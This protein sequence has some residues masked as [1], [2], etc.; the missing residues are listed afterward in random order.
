MYVAAVGVMVHTT[1]EGDSTT[2]PYRT[3]DDAANA[4]AASDT[5]YVGA[6][7]YRELVTMDTSGTTGAGVIQY[8]ADVDGSQTGDPGLVVISAYDD[9]ASTA[10]RAY[11]VQTN[12]K[13]FITWKG[14]VFDGGTVAA[15][16]DNSA[17][18]NL[19]YEEVTFEE[20]VF[21]GGHTETD[22]GVYMDLNEGATP[23]TAGLTFRNCIFEGICRIAWDENAT[24]EV[25]L[26]MV[27]ES[28]LFR[29]S[30][31]TATNEGPGI[32]WDKVA[33]S[34]YMAAGVSVT[35]CM[36][37][38]CYYG[39][40][41]DSVTTAPTSFTI[42]V[43]NCVFARCNKA[44]NAG[45]AGIITSDYNTAYAVNSA[46]TNVTI[47]PNDHDEDRSIPFLG[48][49]HDMPLRAAWG[50]SPYAP[51][52]PFSVVDGVDDYL[53]N[54]IGAGDSSVAPATD[55]YGNSRP[56][57]QQ[58]TA[59][60]IY[61]FDSSDAGP[62]DNSAVWTGDTNI[63]DGDTAT[64]ATTTTTGSTNWIRTEGTTAPAEGGA[65][66]GVDWRYY[67]G[68]SHSDG[69]ATNVKIHTDG[70]GEQLVTQTQGGNTGWTGWQGAISVPSGGWT[71]AKVQALEATVYYDSVGT[72]AAIGAIQI[73]VTH[74]GRHATDDRGAVEA[75]VR[76]EQETTTKRTGDNAMRLEGAGYH[77]FLIP[78]NNASTTV[79]IYGRY[80]SNHT[81]SLPQ[82]QVLNIEG[83]ADQTDTMVAAANTWEELTATFTPTAAGVCRVRVISRDT[84]IDG[85]VFFDDLTVT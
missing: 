73:R 45:T 28:C 30:V 25:N 85:V 6:G 10:A 57:G 80:D 27:L 5:V 84:S 48:G 34:T 32:Q 53:N 83:V 60:D 37:D 18:T 50:W 56:M 17:A 29:P 82:L 36:F 58:G 21:N 2:N 61:Y 81:G 69:A 22:A 3:I 77:D 65:I 79:S 16:G 66:A 40:Y 46:N 14:F 72:T 11:C 39:V 70:Q 33:T 63:D 68:A 19:A 9:E 76:P 23:T 71:W 38:H 13:E 7:V 35:N 26:K 59:E 41:A 42:D 78:V 12:D 4:V 24:A 54:M 20:C 15:V 47:G 8:I 49:I 75:R 43:R 1:T 44:L 31:S 55:L 67:R 74:T 64:E 52:E 62:T 51:W